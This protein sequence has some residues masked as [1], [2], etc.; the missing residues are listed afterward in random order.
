MLLSC[1]ACALF[2]ERHVIARLLPLIY[3]VCA[4]V[5][6]GIATRGE[7][8]LWAVMEVVLACSAAGSVLLFAIW[9]DG[10]RRSGERKR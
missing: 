9:V 3:S 4:G 1:V 6:L 8:G 5:G 2:W 10:R 7:K